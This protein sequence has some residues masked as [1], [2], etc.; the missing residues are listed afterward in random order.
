MKAKLWKRLHIELGLATSCRYSDALLGVCVGM[1]GCIVPNCRKLLLREI[2]LLMFS[3]ADV[4]CISVISCDTLFEIDKNLDTSYLTD[5]Q[6]TRRNF[7]FR[8]TFRN[9]QKSRDKLF[10]RCL[11]ECGPT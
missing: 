3:V 5:P 9:R 6:K 7:E 10:D 4:Y 1:Y 8:P 11:S 2:T